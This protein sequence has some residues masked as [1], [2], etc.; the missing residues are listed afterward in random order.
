MNVARTT[1]DGGRFEQMDLTQQQKARRGFKSC[2]WSVIRLTTAAAVSACGHAAFGQAPSTAPAASP[3][4]QRSTAQTHPQN[5]ELWDVQQMMEDAVLQISRRYNLNKAQENYTRMLLVGRVREFL[6]KHEK[7]VRELLKESIDLRLHPEK[8]TPEVYQR[9]AERAEP[10]YEAARKAILE[11]NDEWREILNEEQ[12]RLHDQDLSQ[13]KDNFTQVNQVIVDWKAGKGPSIGRG[14]QAPGSVSTQPTP[15]EHR[16]IEDNWLAYVATFIQAYQL[17]EKQANAAKAKVYAEFFGKAKAHRER[18]K[19][20][21]AKIEAELKS[22]S[23][24]PNK[25]TKPPELFRRKG[26]LEKPIQKMFVEMDERLN[27]LLRSEQRTNVDKEKKRQLETLYRML[28]GQLLDKRET[29]GSVTSRPDSRPTTSSAPAEE[30]SKAATQPVAPP[31]GPAS[32]PSASRPIAEHPST[33]Q[34]SASQ[35]TTAPAA[36]QP[37]GRPAKDDKPAKAPIPPST[38]PA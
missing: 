19:D 30:S 35:P 25:P 32:Q 22:P 8:G 26:E 36:T 5:P 21:F 6:D 14:A 17:D 20:E 37:K 24:D 7:D 15:V 23:K 29:A 3:A 1:A 12:K 33:S 38:Q 34:P 27:E 16:F 2:L 9:W 28:S 18:Y 11:G 13:M 10:I 31:K 4:T